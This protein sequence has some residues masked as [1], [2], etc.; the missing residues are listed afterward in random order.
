MSLK[1]NSNIDLQNQ[2]IS[3]GS[4]FKPMNAFTISDSYFILFL[5]YFNSY[6]A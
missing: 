5:V 2:I 4:I 1:Q 6:Q 3:S